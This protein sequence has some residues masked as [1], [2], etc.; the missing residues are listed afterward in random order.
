MTNLVKMSCEFLL[1]DDMIWWTFDDV[2]VSHLYYIVQ[3]KGLGELIRLLPTSHDRDVDLHRSVLY[4]ERTR[5]DQ[6]QMALA[7][8][9]LTKQS[10]HVAARI[11][12]VNIVSATFEFDNDVHGS[13]AAPAAAAVHAAAAEWNLSWRGSSRASSRW[14][15]HPESLFKLVFDRVYQ[16]VYSI[17]QKNI[18]RVHNKHERVCI[19][20]HRSCVCTGVIGKSV[21]YS[22]RLA[23]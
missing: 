12:N 17:I 5:S 23:E 10:A 22:V 1:V 20:C 13:A 19:S 6:T 21:Y 4:I 14:S 7:K 11:A 15:S 3:L 8:Y 2:T 16:V 18:A 9:I